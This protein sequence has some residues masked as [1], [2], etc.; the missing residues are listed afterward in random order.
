MAAREDVEH[1]LEAAVQ[2]PGLPVRL[3]KVDVEAVL[4]RIREKNGL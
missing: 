2:E 4:Q 1:S 3:P